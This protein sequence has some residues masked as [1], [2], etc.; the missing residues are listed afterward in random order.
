MDN[1]E[2][3]ILFIFNIY[4]INALDLMNINWPINLNVLH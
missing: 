4:L 3:M 1:C 2:K